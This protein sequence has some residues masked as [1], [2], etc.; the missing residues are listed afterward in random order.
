M[1]GAV[2]EFGTEDGVIPERS[3]MRSGLRRH[4]R[5][6]REMIRKLGAAVLNG[7]RSYVEALELLG[8][9]AVSDLVRQIND[10]KD[11]PNAPSTIARKKSSNPLVNTK[12]LAQSVTYHVFKGNE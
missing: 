7:D 4:R 5:K 9:Q 1:V 3:W 6:H 10:I 2:H 12:H 8:T 11:P